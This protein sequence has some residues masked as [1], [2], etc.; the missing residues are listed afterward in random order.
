MNNNENNIKKDEGNLNKTVKTLKL[1]PKVLKIIICIAFVCGI[2]YLGGVFNSK[3]FLQTKTTKLGFE[4]VGELVVQTG[5]LTVVQD[6]R[7]N[8]EFFN[9]FEI[10]FTESRQIF[11]YDIEIDASVDF[12]KI[13]YD[14]KKEKNEIVVK[15]PHSKIY[16]ATLKTDSFKEYLDSESLFSRI[17][18]KEHNEALKSM[19]NQA[20]ED[21]KSNGILNVADENA[22]RL[23]EGLIKS[24]TE[25]KDY[26]IVYEYIGD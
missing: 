17:N 26:K 5:Y 7:K 21:A 15:L 13:T 12:T 16:K 10:P 4:D 6:N 11:S 8:R 19:E 25:Y 9:L 20:I 24:N 23:I 2:F 14:A 3:H 22:K 18:L 1:F